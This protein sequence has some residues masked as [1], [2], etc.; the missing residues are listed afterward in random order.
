MKTTE[1]ETIKAGTPAKAEVMHFEIDIDASA[2]KVYQTMLDKKKY[3]EWTAVFNAT[4]HFEGS[5]KKGAK[6][7]FLGTDTDGTIG[8][9]V[10]RIKENIPNRFVSIEHL[11]MVQAG[12]E[13]MSGDKVDQWAGAHENY[14]FTEN[15]GHTHLKVDL[16]VAEEWKVY[17]TQ[18]WPAA[19]NKLKT[20][21]EE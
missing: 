16:D 20:I 5:W 15:N 21:C 4:S 6:I 1:K 13:I 3:S 9:M 7:L 14:S 19:L 11:G 17:F 8:G 2:G 18:M 10:S 12:K